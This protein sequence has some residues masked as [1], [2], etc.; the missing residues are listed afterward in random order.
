MTTASDEKQRR[1]VGRRTLDNRD[2]R[3]LEF[4]AYSTTARVDQLAQLSAPGLSPAI[5]DE[6]R[7]RLKKGEPKPPPKPRGGVR[8]NWPMGRYARV[9]AQMQMVNHWIDLG[10]AEKLRPNRDHP[11]WVVVT[12]EGLRRIGA[13]YDDVPFPEGNLEHMY[14]INEVRLFLLQ[15]TKMP[16]HTW[17]SERELQKNEPLKYAGLHVGHRADGVMTVEVD[18]EF[19]RGNETIILEGGEQIAIE[20]ERTRKD[21]KGIETTIFPDLLKTYQRVWYF[22]N[23]GPYDAISKSRAKLPPEQQQRILVYK[24]RPHWWDWKHPQQKEEPDGISA[25]TDR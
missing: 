14:L 5:D 7:K 22:C 21:F 11:L 12:R 9:H 20:V 4:V 15:S 16:K 8:P 24:L 18:T 6:P 25:T 17:T 10:Y 13:P 1:D 2:L 23:P 3:E 19:T